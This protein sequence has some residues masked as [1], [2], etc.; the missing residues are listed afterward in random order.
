MIALS[1]EKALERCRDWNQAHPLGTFVRYWDTTRPDQWIIAPTVSASF[2]HGPGAVVYVR[3]RKLPVYLS[4]LEVVT[5]ETL[6]AILHPAEAS[7]RA[8]RGRDLALPI[9]DRS[10]S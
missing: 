2:L 10:E 4:H 3:G 7:P 1:R 6:Q 9:G 5:R 8:L